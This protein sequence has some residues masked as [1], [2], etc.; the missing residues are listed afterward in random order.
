MFGYV[1]WFICTFQDIAIVASDKDAHTIP[2]QLAAID[3]ERYSQMLA[4]AAA[5][6][7]TH[8]TY[9]GVVNRIAEFV[10]RP[11]AANISC[12]PLPTTALGRPSDM[13]RV[14]LLGHPEIAL[15]LKEEA[16]AEARAG[17]EEAKAEAEK[18]QAK[19]GARAGKELGL[20]VGLPKAGA[21]AGARVGKE[22]AQAGARAGARTRYSRKTVGYE[23]K[24][25]G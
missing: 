7:H 8:F 12:V 17:R 11:W 5:L 20:G 19:A 15:K 21:R 13:R 18:E 22:Q 16:K 3:G 2:K 25:V 24:T 6:K 9:E 10:N 23:S 1:C 4:T 14:W